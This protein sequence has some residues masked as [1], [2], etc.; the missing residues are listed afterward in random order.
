[1]GLLAY[2]GF[3]RFSEFINFKR[4]DIHFKTDHFTLFIYHSKTDNFRDGSRCLIAKTGNVTCPVNMLLRYLTKANIN[5][6]SNDLYFVPLPF[7]KS[8]TCYKLRGTSPLAYTRARELIFDMFEHI[9]LDK[10]KFG[11]HRSGG[12]SAAANAGVSDKLLK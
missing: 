7:F 8:S 4:S 9:G 11:L 12:A 2:T 5:E 6:N 10:S 3:L 1:M